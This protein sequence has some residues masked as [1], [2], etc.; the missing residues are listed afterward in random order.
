[1]TC[2]FVVQ[3]S[4]V[5][6]PWPRFRCAGLLL[7]CSQSF[8]LLLSLNSSACLLVPV[9]VAVRAVL[10]ERPLVFSSVRRPVGRRSALRPR[11]AGD[12]PRAGCPGHRRPCAAPPLP[13]RPPP[14]TTTTTVP[15]TRGPPQS[16]A[17]S[18][19]AP[20]WPPRGPAPARADLGRA[21]VP[22]RASSSSPGPVWL[23]LGFQVSPSLM[24]SHPRATALCPRACVLVCALQASSRG[25][26]VRGRTSAVLQ[27][28][29]R[30]RTCNGR[31]GNGVVV[32]LVVLVIGR[33]CVVGLFLVCSVSWA[34]GGGGLALRAGEASAVEVPAG[35]SG[36]SRPG[37]AWCDN[38]LPCTE[39]R[40][41]PH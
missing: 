19:R 38:L 36:R 7:L 2:K 29:A 33:R 9:S 3:L 23:V 34:S 11:R 5:A 24:C 18:R 32:V 14:P 4:L 1:M 40:L 37:V 21:R 6:N 13:G 27:G 10:Y 31:G 8:S 28:R 22:R 12:R 15:T 16:P 30:A 25:P 35:A 20:A 41:A 17:S 26:L 39:G